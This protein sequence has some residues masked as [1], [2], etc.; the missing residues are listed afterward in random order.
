MQ[1]QETNAHKN[2]LRIETLVEDTILAKK[3]EVQLMIKSTSAVRS[4]EASR[5]VAEIAE[6][7]GAAAE[8][9]IHEEQ[10]EIHGAAVAEGKGIFGRGSTASFALTVRD[11]PTDKLVG[12]LQAATAMPHTT[13]ERTRWCFDVPEEVH[14]DLLRQ[15]SAKAKARAD[16]AAEALGVKVVG[17]VG[18]ELSIGDDHGHHMMQDLAPSAMRKKSVSIVGSL[19]EDAGIELVKRIDIRAT[20]RVT[21]QLSA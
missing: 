6:F 15:V 16:V 8:L 1:T 5:A 4:A 12:L 10:V 21:F 18:C 19:V 9:G 13:H 7:L 11:V 14:L 3:V 20:A 17:V 2:V